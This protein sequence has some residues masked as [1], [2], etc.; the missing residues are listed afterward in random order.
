MTDINVNGTCPSNLTEASVITINIRL[1]LLSIIGFFGIT[2]NIMVILVTYTK[3]GRKSPTD[4]L[5]IN[6]AVIDG[7][8]SGI[9]LPLF[10]VNVAA[11]CNALGYGLCQF[12]GFLSGLC[13]IGSAYSLA[14]L[15]IFRYFRVCKSPSIVLRTR[16]AVY[17]IAL[18]WIITLV[19]C[20]LPFWGLSV[21]EYNFMEKSCLPSWGSSIANR[22]NAAIELVVDFLLP[23]AITL[24]SYLQVFLTLRRIDHNL[25]RHTTTGRLQRRNTTSSRKPIH[26]TIA[27]W[28]L[29]LNFLLCYLT[30]SVLS[31]IVIP[32]SNYK[33]IIPDGLY[34]FAVTMLYVNN[35]VNPFIYLIM[36]KSFRRRY[37]ILLKRIFCWWNK[38]YSVVRVKPCKSDNTREEQS[39]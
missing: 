39:R 35:A 33:I 38:S 36:L 12:H 17:A 29:V 9:R 11:N 22:I 31:F 15:A 3:I 20:L 14:A 4:Y 23:L 34:F 21:Y 10:L 5:I 37:V 7:I 19:I 18:V 2:G 16:H 6:N 28:L 26:L 8:Q 30:W 27:L 25:T 24:I 1:V 32:F 13:F